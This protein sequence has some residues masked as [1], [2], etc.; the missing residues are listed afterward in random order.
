MCGGQAPLLHYSLFFL[1]PVLFFT[2]PIS[3]LHS[4][5]LSH[6]RNV[7]ILRA[8]VKGS[9]IYQPMLEPMALVNTATNLLVPQKAWRILISYAAISFL[10]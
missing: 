6:S 8:G 7:N 2:S 1:T 10:T 5:F 3:F 4:F 9:F